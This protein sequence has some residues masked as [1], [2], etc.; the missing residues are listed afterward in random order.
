MSALKLCSFLTFSDVQEH[1]GAVERG[2]G[3]ERSRGGGQQR[4][5]QQRSSRSN[6]ATITRD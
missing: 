5:G 2:H 3:G 4:P 1:H 6:N